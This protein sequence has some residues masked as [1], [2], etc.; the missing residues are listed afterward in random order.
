MADDP[1]DEAED[2]AA[3]QQVNKLPVS[4]FTLLIHCSYL[5]SYAPALIRT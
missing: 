3:I 2:T 5:T 4:Q 1:D